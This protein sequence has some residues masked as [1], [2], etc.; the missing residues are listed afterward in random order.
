MTKRID[1]SLLADQ[2][3]PLLALLAE[4]E[5]ALG[6]ETVIA[7][8]RA[9]AALPAGQRRIA[10][11]VADC[12]ELLTGWGAAAVSP[13]VLR[14]VHA[15]VRAGATTVVEPS[16]PGCGRQRQL[17]RPFN[18]LRL[19]HGCTRKAVAMPCGRCGQTRPPARRDDN[20]YAIC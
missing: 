14:F 13:G 12:P 6:T 2:V 5:P 10:E 4:L 3:G 19:C 11:E 1:Q 7:A 9:A 17:A 20:G 8:L 15:L 18:G 16:C